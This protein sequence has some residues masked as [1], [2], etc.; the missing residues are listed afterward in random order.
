[1][2]Y[3]RSGNE[4]DAGVR[5]EILIRLMGV[6]RK[7]I[8]D[9]DP[10]GPAPDPKKGPQPKPV[11]M[12]SPAAKFYVAKDGYAN[13]Y[14]NKQKTETVLK[15]LHKQGDFTKLA[16]KWE[17]DGSIKLLKTNTGS[18]LRIEIADEKAKAGSG[19]EPV[20]RMKMANLVVPEELF[21]AKVGQLTEDYKKP[22]GSG[23]F[24]AAMYLY[25]HL[26]V[27]GEK[28]FGTE[29][30]HAGHE[31]YYPPSGDRKKTFKERKTLA[32]VVNARSGPYLIRFFFNP[33]EK[34]AGRLE[35]MEVRLSDNEDPCEVY[36]S[37][38]KQVD[39]RWL[40][41]TLT[42]VYGDTT[43]GTIELSS[44]KMNPSE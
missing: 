22:Q 35:Y 38:Y 21:P 44:I 8:D 2:E 23:G 29:F 16:G 27:Q 17:L 4:E 20:V 10:K 12:E 13:F 41:H 42:V 25:R 32:E 33:Q 5:K 39:G 43:Y 26:L 15:N 19:V 11:N 18:D 7:V 24:L 1:M 36:F 37:N 31:P 9:T 28:A 34:E 3:R 6:Q 30:V 14:F 40:P